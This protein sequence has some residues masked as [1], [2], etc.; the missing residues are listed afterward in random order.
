MGIKYLIE[1]YGLHLTNI[2]RKEHKG[3]YYKARLLDKE[4]HFI[5]DVY[6]DGEETPTVGKAFVDLVPMI[7]YFQEEHEGEGLLELLLRRDIKQIKDYF[8]E[9]FQEIL[10]KG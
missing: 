4:N 1:K 6:F 7:E 10:K 9:D 2:Q 5:C 8:G 3:V